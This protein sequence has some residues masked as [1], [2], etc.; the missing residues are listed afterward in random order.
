MHDRAVREKRSEAP[1]IGIGIGSLGA[2]DEY[3]VRIQ[4]VIRTAEC[5]IRS[6]ES[7][8]VD[9]LIHV[10][11]DGLLRSHAEGHGQN[12][13]QRNVV[14]CR[15]PFHHFLPSFSFRFVSLPESPSDH[16]RAARNSFNL[17]M[18]NLEPKTIMAF[19]LFFR[20][21]RPRK[22][23]ANPGKVYTPR[24]AEVDGEP[25]HRYV[26]HSRSDALAGEMGQG[27]PEGP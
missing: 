19:V 9:H 22:C 17:H 24:T 15:I 8:D 11:F 13:K 5:A 10:V 6:S 1:G 16:L 4:A 14:N 2:A 18:R 12:S 21:N 20:E 27:K 25:P 23:G 7:A 26:R 3:A